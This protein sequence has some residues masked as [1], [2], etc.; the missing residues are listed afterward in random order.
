VVILL[1]F[2]S[3]CILNLQGRVSYTVADAPAEVTDCLYHLS[4]E[5]DLPDDYI[6]ENY[7]LPDYHAYIQN[8]LTDRRCKVLDGNHVDLTISVSLVSYSQDLDGRRCSL[9]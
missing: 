6:L 3:E 7:Q 1:P 9:C 4:Q 8:L 2:A 5:G